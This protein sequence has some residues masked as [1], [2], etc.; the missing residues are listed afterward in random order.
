MTAGRH[1]VTDTAARPSR[2]GG[3]AAQRCTRGAGQV[4]L[5]TAPHVIEG[6]RAVG[7]TGTSLAGSVE[8]L[9]AAESL[10]DNLQRALLSNRRIGMAIGVLLSRHMTEEQAFEALR[11]ASMR[12]NVELRDLAEEVVHTGSL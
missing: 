1:A 9:R 7:R 3:A 8:R 5:A 10:A 12:R 6:C 4:S 11:E 2:A